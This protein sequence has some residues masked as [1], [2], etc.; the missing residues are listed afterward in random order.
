VLVLIGRKLWPAGSERP[1][2][3]GLR[4]VRSGPGAGRR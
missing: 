1:S 4:R 3:P 2:D